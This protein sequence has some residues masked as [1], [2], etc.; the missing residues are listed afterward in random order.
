MNGVSVVDT[1]GLQRLILAICSTGNPATRLNR[2]IIEITIR[3]IVDEGTVNS[4]IMFGTDPNRCHTMM[5]S[6]SFTESKIGNHITDR[7]ISVKTIAA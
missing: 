1:P 5:I 4:I 3:P 7:K 6:S 2:N